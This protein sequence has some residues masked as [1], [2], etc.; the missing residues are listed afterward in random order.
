MKDY[1]APVDFPSVWKIFGRVVV[2]YNPRVYSSSF[3]WAG[4]LIQS[5][6][7]S[8]LLF[9][10]HLAEVLG[11]LARDEAIWR[12]TTKQGMSPESNMLLEGIRHWPSCII[13]V[14]KAIVPWVFSYGFACNGI[15]SIAIFPLLTL[16]VLFLVLGFFS[17]YLI[18]VAPKG[19]QPAT[20]GDV[21]ALVALVDDWSHDTIFWGDKGEYQH[22]EGVRVAGTAGS[23]L[24]DLLPGVMYKG[25]PK[26][27]QIA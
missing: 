14:Y 6:A 3:E 7:L 4:L 20:Y 5:A 21:Q 15:I 12:A 24:P 1:P 19:L 13:F 11:G 2:Q 10:L 16:A 17:E 27:P 8:T 22:V 18:R 26:E 23:Q 25:L 9:G